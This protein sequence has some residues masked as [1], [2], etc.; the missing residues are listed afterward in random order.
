MSDEVDSEI[1]RLQ[2]RISKLEAHIANLEMNMIPLSHEQRIKIVTTVGLLQPK[3]SQAQLVR[4]GGEADGGYVIESPKHGSTVLSL[5]VGSEIT[6]DLHL[7][8]SYGC[9]VYAFDPYVERPVNA[10]V[11]FIFSQIGL[12][13]SE[14]KSELEFMSI[15][16][17]L[18]KLPAPPNLV[19][20]DIEGSEL[21]LIDSF[22][23]LRDAEQIIIEFHRLDQIIFDDFFLKF[24]KLLNHILESHEPFHVHGNND[25]PTLRIAAAVWPSIIEVSFRKRSAPVD[26]K[27]N[28]GPW[29]HLLDRPNNPI[30]PELFLEPF[31]GRN[32]NYRSY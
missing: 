18:S 30:R 22:H 25:G 26:K 32:A 7:I 24:T 23:F 6:A 29:P 15:D 16:R 31:F 2:S 14:E 21:E 28:Y 9:E 8:E 1:T 5:G 10:P 12:G 19:F 17:I 13:S 11:E 27:V 4:I 3:I 20:I